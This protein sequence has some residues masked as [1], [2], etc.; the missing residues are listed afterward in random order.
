MFESTLR[1]TPTIYTR[2]RVAIPPVRLL[3]KAALIC[4]ARN[5]YKIAVIDSG[6]HAT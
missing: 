1:A 6:Q 5:T 4:L 3:G 2:S